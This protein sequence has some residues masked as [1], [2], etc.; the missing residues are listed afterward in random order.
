MRRFRWVVPLLAL[1]VLAGCASGGAINAGG[2]SPADTTSPSASS[3][4][5]TPTTAAAG[6][7]AAAGCAPGGGGVPSGAA[8]APTLDVDGDGRPDTMW[9]ATGPAADGSVPFGV[10]TSSGR[11][12]SAATSSGSPRPRQ[13]LIADVTGK[14]ELVAFASD[15]RQVPL[16]AVSGCSFVPVQNPQGQQYTFDLGFTGFGTGVGCADVDGD[17]VRD[18][19]GLELVSEA[20]GRSVHRTVIRLS[21]PTA[22]NGA[23]DTVPVSS[24]ADAAAAAT[25]TCGPLTI[26]HDGVSSGR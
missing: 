1:P 18:L 3:A 2:R 20:G 9:I 10:T 13:L 19:L 17:G 26:D 15:G 12:F 5:A 6:S 25:V 4:A 11:T 24:D 16:F 7:R 23:T 21:G 8:T 22:T 14:G